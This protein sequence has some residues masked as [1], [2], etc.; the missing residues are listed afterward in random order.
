MEKD[1]EITC[2]Y[3]DYIEHM[4]HFDL[5]ICAGVAVMLDFFSY[6]VSEIVPGTE[7][8]RYGYKVLSADDLE[9]LKEVN[10]FRFYIKGIRIREEENNARHRTG[11]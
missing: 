1:F 5:D 2:S 8:N 7:R 11:S 6:K 10:Q 4:K 9:A 3:P